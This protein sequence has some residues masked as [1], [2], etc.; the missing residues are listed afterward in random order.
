R[1]SRQPGV[2]D[3][4]TPVAWLYPLFTKDGTR[5]LVPGPEPHTYV[6]HDAATLAPL[7]TVG[8]GPSGPANAIGMWSNRPVLSPDSRRLAIGANTYSTPMTRIEA[9]L[10]QWLGRPV[11]FPGRRGDVRLYDLATRADAGRLP[12]DG[13][14]LG[15]APD[16]RTLWTYAEKPG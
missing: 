14:V 8:P 7:A 4:P 16:G 2:P 12:A 3:D 10:T 15:F 13:R 5:F 6:I 11:F 1:R 9:W